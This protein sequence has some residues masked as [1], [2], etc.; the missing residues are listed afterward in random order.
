[1]A[2]NSY[3]ELNAP[4]LLTWF[5]KITGGYII[6]GRDTRAIQ[7]FMDNRALVPCQM[8]AGMIEFAEMPDTKDI[9]TFMRRE[10][11]WLEENVVAAEAT[12]VKYLTKQEHPPCYW[13][14]M[15]LLEWDVDDALVESNFR[16]AKLEL[17]QYLGDVLSKP[18]SLGSRGRAVSQR[19]IVRAPDAH[20]GSGPR[21]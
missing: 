2:A 11:T 13:R 20:P 9:Y 21:S 14:Y 16:A 1:M 19:R 18:A 17:E 8:L 15:D 6:K 5:V 10:D 4:E 7:Y 3:R 12:V